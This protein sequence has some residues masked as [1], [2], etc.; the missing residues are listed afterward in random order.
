MAKK[1]ERVPSL[2]E[3]DLENRLKDDHVG[4]SVLASR[5]NTV[6]PNPLGEEDYVGTD[7]I[8]QNHANDTEKPLAAESGVEE[9]AEAFFNDQFDLSDADEDLV[10][11]D[12]GLGGKALQTQPA[13]TQPDVPDVTV[14]ASADVTHSG[15]E[16]AKDAEIAELKERVAALESGTSEEPADPDYE[17]PPAPPEP[18]TNS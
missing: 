15:D 18:P 14:G 7:A 16:A 10:V 17:E 6:Q 2:A 8:Y 3:V 5:R 12:P 13:S 1:P 9:K 11:D 4:E